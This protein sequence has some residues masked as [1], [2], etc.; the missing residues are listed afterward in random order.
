MSTHAPSSDP[1]PRHT[2]A[3]A[4]TRPITIITGAGSGVGAATARLLA[5]RGHG[6]LV[7]YHRSE[8][9]ALEVVRACIEAGT[10]AIAV[11][12]DVGDDAV[13]RKL[14]DCAI[15]RW[16]RIDG[17][18]NCAAMTRFVPLSELE[19]VDAQEFI[20]LYR[21]NAIGPFQMARAVAPHMQEGASI[22]CVSSIAGQL[23]SGSSF[24][25]VLSKRAICRSRADR[26]HLLQ[27]GDCIR[28]RMAARSG[29]HDDRA[30]HGGRW[31]LQPGAPTT[32]CGG[33]LTGLVSALK[34]PHW[35]LPSRHVLSMKSPF[36]DV[37]SSVLDDPLA[38]LSQALNAQGHHVT[39]AK[40]LGRFHAAGHAGR[41][42]GGDDVAG[43]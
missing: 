36:I 25:Y 28:H 27:R 41:C 37:R 40:E 20:D 2:A 29:L 39:F 33:A 6:V 34:A 1:T 17:L 32:V 38:L 21:V 31:R 13:C 24:P 9:A 3:P 10:D 19:Q 26:P 43:V 4:A 11:S 15:E 35:L 18:V 16:G 7:H 5:A 12:G 30:A 42:A 23:G 14:A 8:A 22:V